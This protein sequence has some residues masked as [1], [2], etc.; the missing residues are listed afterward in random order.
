[1]TTIVLAL[2]GGCVLAPQGTAEERA[3]LRESGQAYETPFDRRELPDLPEQPTWKQLLRRA[4]LANGDL[5]AAHFEWKA[6]VQRID[7]ASAW[8]NSNVELGFEYMFSDEQIK[9]WDRTT[10][11]AGF[12]PSMELTLPNKAA[13]SGKVALNDA[14][15][16]GLRFQQKKFDLQKQVL[17]AWLDY[18]RMNE[19]VK[20]QEDNVAL[21][22]M[23]SETAA[24]RVQAGGAPQQDLIKAQIQ[25]RLAEN[26]LATMQSELVSM[27]AMLNGLVAR[28]HDAVLR[29]PPELPKPRQLPIDDARIIAVAVE[30]NQELAALAAQVQGRRD[31]LELARMQ[32]LPDVRPFAGITGSVEQFVGAMVMLPTAM[33]M[34]RASIEESRAMLQAQEAMLRQGRFGRGAEVVAAMLL[35]RNADRQA[36]L[37][38][39]TVLPRARQAMDSARQSY[40]AGT[41]TFIEMA[42]AQRTLL[43]VRRMIIDARIA[44]EKALAELECLIC[45]DLETLDNPDA[46]RGAEESMDE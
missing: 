10:I 8:P 36:A 15:A 44:R 14:R 41:L 39:E 17:D 43:D 16:A 33:P 34:I 30:K 32:W 22:Q 37:F 29:P 1:M 40:A 42:D 38:Q 24:A 25:H 5:E 2:P 12:D 45:V 9:S 26:E 27:R 23:L 21:L 7:V 3:A 31:A 19:L 46:P 11:T 20:V 35:S 18:V 6:A 28:P 4:F 13:Q